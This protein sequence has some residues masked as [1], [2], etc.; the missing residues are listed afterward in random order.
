MTALLAPHRRQHLCFYGKMPYQL[1]GKFAMSTDCYATQNPIDFVG[2]LIFFIYNTT[3]SGHGCCAEVDK[4]KS[5]TV[6]TC[7]CV[8]APLML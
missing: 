7:S 5:S 4:R 3:G 8:A 1:Y 6:A 2:H